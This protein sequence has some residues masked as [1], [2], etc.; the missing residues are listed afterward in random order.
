MFLQNMKTFIN[1]R[2][3]IFIVNLLLLN[4]MII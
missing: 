4:R 1:T 3:A 2:V